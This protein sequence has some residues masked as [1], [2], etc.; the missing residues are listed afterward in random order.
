[1][2]QEYESKIGE[3]LGEYDEH[4]SEI[5]KMI[6]ELEKI[7]EEI[8]QLIPTKLDKRFARIFEEKV[9]AITILFGTLLEM[10]KE[11]A[12]SVKD[13]IEIRR[14]VKVLDKDFDFES[15]LDIRS[16]SEKVESFKDTRERFKKKEFDKDV[17]E[18][19]EGVEV[20]GIN[21]TITT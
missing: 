17:M 5:K 8:D 19:P 1:M 7:R 21:T 4:R 14:K 16:L 3:L 15:D 9:K 12:K 11:I 10:R 6:V 13:E 20:P 2:E 18:L